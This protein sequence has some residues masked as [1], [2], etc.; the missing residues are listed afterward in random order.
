[1]VIRWEKPVIVQDDVMKV[2]AFKVKVE[3]LLLTV[4]ILRPVLLP[5]DLCLFR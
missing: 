2:F 4:T 3:N 5:K 1:M